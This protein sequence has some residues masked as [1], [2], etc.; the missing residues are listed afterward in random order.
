MLKFAKDYERVPMEIKRGIKKE[1][2]AH[3][4]AKPVY[5]K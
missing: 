4:V 1:V 3:G 5:Y 2:T